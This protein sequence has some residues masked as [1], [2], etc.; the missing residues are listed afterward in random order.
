MVSSSTPG[1]LGVMAR[2]EAGRIWG[3]GGETKEVRGREKRTKRSPGL[4]LG[5]REHMKLQLGRALDGA[6][7]S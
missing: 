4:G 3:G 5:S 1:I 7:L 6:M 2:R